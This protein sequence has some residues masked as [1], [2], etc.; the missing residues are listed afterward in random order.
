[1]L[2]VSRDGL[3]VHRGQR[4]DQPRCHHLECVAVTLS[5]G[6][7]LEREAYGVPVLPVSLLNQS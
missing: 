1:M 4:L 6:L 3:D 7:G 2:V 5:V